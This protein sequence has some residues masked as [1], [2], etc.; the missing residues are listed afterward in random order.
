MN[1]R[2]TEGNTPERAASQALV[3]SPTNLSRTLT[4]HDFQRTLRVSHSLSAHSPGVC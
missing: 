3:D 1:N 4:V 2:A